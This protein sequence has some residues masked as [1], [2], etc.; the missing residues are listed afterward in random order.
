MGIHS[1]RRLCLANIPLFAFCL[2]LFPRRFV[3]FSSLSVLVGGAEDED[4]IGF[5]FL[6]NSLFPMPEVV[7]GR[8]EKREELAMLISMVSPPFLSARLSM[9]LTMKSL[10]LMEARGENSMMRM[11]RPLNVRRCIFQEA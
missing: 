5:R 1:K 9:I 2:F 11:M 3:R 4:R 8:R 10:L 7:R 6:G